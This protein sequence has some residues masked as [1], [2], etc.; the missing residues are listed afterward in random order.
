MADPKCAKETIVRKPLFTAILQRAKKVGKIEIKEIEF[1]P[2]TK[3]GSA[4]ASL[5]SGR[6][7]RQRRVPR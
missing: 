4:P 2:R 1:H 5:P 7:Y 3:D 6:L